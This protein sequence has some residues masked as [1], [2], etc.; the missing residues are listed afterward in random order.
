MFGTVQSEDY[1]A[2]ISLHKYVRVLQLRMVIVALS[3]GHTQEPWYSLF[4]TITSLGKNLIY[5]LWQI[6]F[7]ELFLKALSLLLE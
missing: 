4:N 1:S 2:A 6:W 7:E 5:E 3:L